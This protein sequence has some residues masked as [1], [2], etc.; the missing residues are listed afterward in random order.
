MRLDAHRI[1]LQLPPGWEG[2]VWKR[3]SGQPVVHAAN[4]ALPES[5]GDFGVAAAE[6]MPR[7][8]VLVVLVEYEPSLA[9]T[10]L[11]AAS[12]PPARLR[13]GDFSGRTLLRALPGQAGAQRFFTAAAGRPFCLYVVIGS[14]ADAAALAGQATTLLAGLSIAAA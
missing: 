14:A 1:A 3:E 5:D 6:R 8:G 7:H 11:F 9:G 4:F 13:G 2:R 10:A 12:G